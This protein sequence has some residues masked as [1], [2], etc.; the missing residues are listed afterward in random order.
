MAVQAMAGHFG[1]V[2]ANLVA[3]VGPSIGACCYEVGRDVKER[4]EQNGHSAAGIARWFQTEPAVS[5]RNPPFAGM[6]RE[7]RADHWFFDAWTTARDQLVDAGVP[8]ASIFVA[9]LCTASHPNVLCSYRR[10]GSAAGRI[11]GAI[12]VGATTITAEGAEL[13]EP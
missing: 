1:S 3:A 10:E 9:E 12:R 2:P 11:A 4:F 6:S 8:P 7:R 5:S 13:A